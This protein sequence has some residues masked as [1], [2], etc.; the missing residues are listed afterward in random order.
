MFFSS[1]LLPDAVTRR[2]RT[3][4]CHLLLAFPEPHLLVLLRSA[5]PRP[6][7]AAAAPAAAVVVPAAAAAVRVDSEPTGL[8][9]QLTPVGRDG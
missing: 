4:C 7:V 9:H 1:V 2:L 5:L 3:F 6:A 8:C